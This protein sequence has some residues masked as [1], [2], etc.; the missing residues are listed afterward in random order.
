[1][2]EEMGLAPDEPGK[3]KNMWTC[4]GYL[5]SCADTA[6]VVSSRAARAVVVFL[7]VLPPLSNNRTRLPHR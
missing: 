4:M 3:G 5:I 7:I 1:R 2:L 6:V